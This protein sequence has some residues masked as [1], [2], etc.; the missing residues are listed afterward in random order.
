MIRPSSGH[1]AV[2]P[3]HA[4][5]RALLAEREGSPDWPTRV[6]AARALAQHFP[7]DAQPPEQQPAPERVVIYLKEPPDDVD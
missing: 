3:Q 5:R 7:A 2:R 1:R 6:S 4:R